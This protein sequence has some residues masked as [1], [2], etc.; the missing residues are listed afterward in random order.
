[1]DLEDHA[2]GVVRDK[3]VFLLHIPKTGGNT[4]VAQFLSFLPIETVW[5]PPPGL[6]LDREGLREAARR[7]DGLRFIHGHVE[8]EIGAELP[9]D[10][11]RLITFIR[12]PVRLAVSHYLY[13]RQQAANRL[14][15]AASAMPID[16]FYRRFPGMIA[17][18][19]TAYLARA[20]GYASPLG[21][22]LGAAGV[23]C[24]LAALDRFA[25]V[26]VTERM[27]ESIE[28]MAEALG[29]PLFPV[30]R[31]NTGVASRDEAEHCASRLLRDEFLMGLGADFAL[32]R[33]AEARLCRWQR[34]RRRNALAARLALALSGRASMPEVVAT[35]PGLALG[36][37]EGWLPQGWS[38]EPSRASR[39][40]WTRQRATL[41]L[42][43]RQP[44]PCR[45]QL[46]VVNTMQFDAAAIAAS[47]EEMMLPVSA[48]LA[49]GGTSVLLDIA[50]PAE[51]FAASGSV[52]IALSAPQ[53]LPF[54]ELDPA[55]QDHEPRG[56]AV[57]DF[58]L[59]AAPC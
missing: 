43:A 41:L 50:I 21:A 22:P 32:R 47:A 5:P 25:F 49:E 52:E 24:A 17:D 34:G 51:A 3:P 26:G 28:A 7:L 8:D 31:E 38:G 19:Q 46:L 16:V 15:A 42:A 57:R 27:Q 44:V 11:L 30:G 33:A 6:V 56:F 2:P 37:L 14:H 40:W 29:L 48:S 36:F 53:A 18:P 59:S 39:Y 55:I 9:T 1:M 45:L 54:S 20:M 13:L 12:H 10:A 58:I 35:A 4:I 23:G